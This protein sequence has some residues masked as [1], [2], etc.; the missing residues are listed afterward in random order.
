M[1]KKNGTSGDAYPTNIVVWVV[2]DPDMTRFFGVSDGPEYEISRLRPENILE[3]VENKLIFIFGT[4]L[5]TTRR[6]V[7]QHTQK[8]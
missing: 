1:T 3:I 2:P 6:I 4:A 7:V 5:E 8:N